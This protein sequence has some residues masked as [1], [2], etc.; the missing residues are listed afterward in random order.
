MKE[1]LYKNIA[2]TFIAINIW[3][4]YSFFDYFNAETN[5]QYNLSGLTLAFNFIGSVYIG[6]AVGIL[7]IL[8]RILE[9]KGNLS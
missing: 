1:Q 3:I 2:F 4:L 6:I 9:I 5:D 8:L 7:A